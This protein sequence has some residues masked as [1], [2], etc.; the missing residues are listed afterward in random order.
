[1]SKVSRRHQKKDNLFVKQAAIALVG[2]V[3]ITNV[4]S[5]VETGVNM[6]QFYGGDKNSYIQTDGVAEKSLVIAFSGIDGSV[7][8]AVMHQQNVF[9]NTGCAEYPVAA[10]L[11]SP[12][13]AFYGVAG[14]V[15]AMAGG[16]FFGVQRG[17]AETAPGQQMRMGLCAS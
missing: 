4:F 14:T 10:F 17:L 12:V 8:G 3:G 1:M 7:N 15:G 2:A 9:H 13:K 16:A 6:H 11:P 5:F